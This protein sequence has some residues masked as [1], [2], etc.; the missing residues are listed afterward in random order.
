MYRVLEEADVYQLIANKLRETS[1]NELDFVR[2]R[3]QVERELKLI[4][5]YT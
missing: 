4:N 1:F 5:R 2:W 3:K